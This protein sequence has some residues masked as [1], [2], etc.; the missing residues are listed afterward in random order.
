VEVWLANK[1]FP[2]KCGLTWD[3]NVDYP[4]VPDNSVAFP[5][6][7]FI[8][9]N[10]DD[11][12]QPKTINDDESFIWP[13]EDG[14][15]IKNAPGEFVVSKYLTPTTIGTPLKPDACFYNF[16]G[17]GSSLEDREDSCVNA[18]GCVWTGLDC[19]SVYNIS[20]ENLDKNSC[21]ANKNVCKYKKKK[22]SLKKLTKTN[23]KP[24]KK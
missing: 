4:F 7:E 24:K 2:T 23:L 12:R 18:Q 15:K 10:K 1:V 5:V 9:G 6:M 22:C 20:C 11:P 21:K 17:N 19:V 8:K 13:N 16:L 3:D 14:R